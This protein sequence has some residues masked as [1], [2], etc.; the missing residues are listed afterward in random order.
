MPTLCAFETTLIVNGFDITQVK[1]AFTS[2][3]FK[4]HRL[5]FYYVKLGKTGVVLTFRRI[6]FSPVRFAPLKLLLANRLFKRVYTLWNNWA[7]VPIYPAN[8]FIVRRLQSVWCVPAPFTSF[9]P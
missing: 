8:H 5:S 1:A 4:Y 2:W 7:V 3:I 6:C 9:T